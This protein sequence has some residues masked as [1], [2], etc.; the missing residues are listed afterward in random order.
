MDTSRGKNKQ[1]TLPCGCVYVISPTFVGGGRQHVCGCERV[2]VISAEPIRDI[3]F[4]VAE[5]IK[6]KMEGE[7]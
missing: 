5:T 7:G 3:K 4:H 1:L 2:W 6:K